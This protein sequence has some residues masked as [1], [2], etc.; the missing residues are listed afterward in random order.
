M[1]KTHTWKSEI[2]CTAD[3]YRIYLYQEVLCESYD[4]MQALFFEQIEEKEYLTFCYPKE[5]ALNR[6]II[7]DFV[8]E[9][10]QTGL[11]Y[12]PEKEL[13]DYIVLEIVNPLWQH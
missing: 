6:E 1:A 12:Y 2:A 3:N 10:L 13:T 11:T 8:M 4:A 7:L 5:G 9:Q